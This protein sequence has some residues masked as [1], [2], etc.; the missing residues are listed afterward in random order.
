MFELFSRFCSKESASHPLPSDSEVCL[1]VGDVFVDISGCMNS[2]PRLGSYK[3]S[4]G[5]IDIFIPTEKSVTS[6][7]RALA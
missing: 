7:D 2:H 5:N 6:Q 1:G 3:Q 4:R